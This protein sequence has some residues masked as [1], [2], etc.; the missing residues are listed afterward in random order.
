MS[1]YLKNKQNKTKWLLK[2]NHGVGEMI[3]AANERRDTVH[4]RLVKK[5]LKIQ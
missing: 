2:Q 3:E 1:L 4:Q 5:L